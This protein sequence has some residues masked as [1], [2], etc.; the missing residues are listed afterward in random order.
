[1]FIAFIY[2]YCFS[3]FNMID[4]VIALSIFKSIRKIR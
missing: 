4:Y 1:M 3:S 2:S